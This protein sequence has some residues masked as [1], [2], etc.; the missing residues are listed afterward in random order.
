MT[1]WDLWQSW[2]RQSWKRLQIWQKRGVKGFKTQILENS[3]TD[4]HHTRGVN[5]RWL[6]GDD[7]F[8]TSTRQWGKILRRCQKP[9]WHQISW[10]KDFNFKTAF[11]LIYKMEEKYKKCKEASGK[12]RTN[13]IT[14]WYGLDLCL[15]SN[16]MSNCNPQC[17]RRDLVGGDGIMGTGF[18]L[19]V[20]MIL[21]MAT[22]M[23]QLQSWVVAA[24]TCSLQSL[25]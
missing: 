22:F 13:Q 19:R 18:P 23:L 6:D 8:Q 10:L 2:S 14:W 25:K 1:S 21:S 5:W 7:C 3:R 11:D 16:L 20:L 15:H 4:R 9:K 12:L 24:E 17:W